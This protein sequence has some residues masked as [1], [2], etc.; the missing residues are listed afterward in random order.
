MAEKTITVIP[1]RKR[2]GSRKQV[3]EEKPRLRVAAYCRVSTDRD[4]QESSYEAQVEHYTEFIDRNPEWQLAGIYADDGISGTN[5]KKR[6]E[7]NRMIEDCM[8][9]KIDMV[10]TKS[11]SRFARN[12]L[13]CLKYIRKLKEKNIS[14]YFE[15][16]NINTMDAKGEV[17]LTIMASLAQ[18]E[19]QS[20]SQNVKLGL[21]FRYQ[22]GKVQVNH[23]R[24]LGYTKDDEGN[25]VIVPEEAEIVKR[26]YR[27]YLEG[28]SLLQ[29]G[30]GL[31]TDGILTAAGKAQWRP[32]TLQKILRNEK[33]IGDALLQKTYTVDFL[34]KK[35]VKNNGIVPQYYVEGS[36]EAIIPRD[37][38]MQVQ[39]EMVRRANLHS[40]SDRKKRVY[41]S[42]YALS[43]IVYCPKCGD[44]YRRIAWNN[45]G[46][47]S[48]VWRCCTRVERGPKV[49]DA[50]TIQESDLQNA[51]ARAI[52]RVLGGREGFLPLLEENIEVV[53]GCGVDDEIAEIDCRLEEQQQELL[54][55]AN[56]KKDYSKVADEIDRLREEKQAIL[57]READRDGR[58]QRIE[59]MKAFLQ[60]QAD[61]PLEYDERLVRRLIE[62][63][64]VYEDKVVVE[65]KSGLETDVDL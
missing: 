36:H 34:S 11:I 3:T 24:F 22:A 29:I 47:H 13:D 43:S 52:N 1:A 17:L 14:V 27:E 53:I 2:V 42:K 19:S 59:E 30:K 35:R 4:E 49:C 65:F 41:S 12:T 20:L 5:T 38:Y 33:Y 16:E 44:I 51:V 32:T 61:T 10:I 18:Q 48:T 23:N 7:F 45:R 63:V 25:L 37:L 56:A 28:A 8:A 57:M 58:R 60:E 54:N 50:P 64:T 15:K 31:E 39:E 26:I 46:K 55:L 9:S 21:Q 6:E 40:G 62:K